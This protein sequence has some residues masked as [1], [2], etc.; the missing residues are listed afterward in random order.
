M[1]TA[2]GQVLRYSAFTDAGEGGNPAGAPATFR[3]APTESRTA[4]SRPR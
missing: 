3:C 2:D 4:S 1:S